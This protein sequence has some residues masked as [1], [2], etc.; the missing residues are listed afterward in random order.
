[1]RNSQKSADKKFFSY[2]N[3]RFNSAAYDCDISTIPQSRGQKKH[4]FYL[5]PNNDTLFFSFRDGKELINCGDGRTVLPDLLAIKDGD[6]DDVK[7][8]IERHG[9]LLPLA[10]S[11]EDS[12]A[13]VLLF[14]LINRLK[15]TVSLMSAFA[16]G[17]KTF[18]YK[19]IMALTMYLLLTP[20]TSIELVGCKEPYQTCPHG[21]S[22][23]WRNT[24]FI[25]EHGAAVTFEEYRTSKGLDGIINVID[26]VRPP[27]YE[28]NI[29]QYSR[30]HLS[31]SNKSEYE[32]L[33]VVDKATALYIGAKNVPVHCRLAIDFLFHFCFNVGNIKEW[34]HKGELI[35]GDIPSSCHLNEE[36]E[37]HVFT[38]KTAE[39]HS[40]HPILKFLNE[41]EESP[42]ELDKLKSE[43][44]HPPSIAKFDDGFDN[45]LAEALIVLAKHTL[46]TEIEY[47]LK[48]VVPSYDTDTL[49]P[50]WSIRSLL[51]GIYFSLF[52]VRAK[53]EQ[54]RICAK[55]NCDRY[56]LTKI[57]ST[58]Q[59]YCSNRCSNAAAQDAHRK[60]RK[61]SA[62]N[63]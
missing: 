51:S 45:Q 12:V 17:G 36:K 50:A 43:I 20:Q 47:N 37:K 52:N 3:I 41:H 32:K 55:P 58:K 4:A 46:K 29:R 40:L 1:M 26:T 39:L 57:Y 30:F 31:E 61:N 38:K 14:A 8:F 49:T 60:K 10:P 59:K 53:E 44:R 5:F 54:Y 19:K 27:V 15:A 35:L 56:F 2:D 42:E 21:M 24:N 16:E 33:S 11:A 9:F 62:Q 28:V 23:I 48:G 6:V 13:A 18:D 22:H 7:A 34:N 63:E 25:N